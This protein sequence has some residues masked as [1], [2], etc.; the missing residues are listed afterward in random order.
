MSTTDAGHHVEDIINLLEAA[1]DSEWN[2]TPPRVK[3]YWSVPQGQ[4]DPGADMAPILY[5]FSPTDSSLD[6]FSIDGDHYQQTN[7]VEVQA[8]SLDEAEV[9]LLQEDVVRILSGYLDDNSTETPYST[10]EPTTELDFREQKNP[11]D[12]ESYIM[13]VE[14][15]TEGLSDAN[16]A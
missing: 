13:A 5:L 2:A 7:S 9:K 1:P 14:V 4:K 16:V 15:E 10:V 11:R 3:K 12:T 8:W 6:R